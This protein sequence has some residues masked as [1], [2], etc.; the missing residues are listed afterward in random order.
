MSVGSDF[1]RLKSKAAS[2][3]TYVKLPKDAAWF[4]VELGN[5]G[6]KTRPLPTPR[7]VARVVKPGMNKDQVHRLYGKASMVQCE[8]DHELHVYRELGLEISY[9]C[10]V[11]VGAAIIEGK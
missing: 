11:A 2:D 10:E 6:L 7:L 5:S 3:A 4:T 9:I 1:V 8:G